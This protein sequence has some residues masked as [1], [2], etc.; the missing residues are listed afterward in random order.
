MDNFLIHDFLAHEMGLLYIGTVK[1]FRNNICKFHFTMPAYINDMW[2]LNKWLTVTIFFFL[3][4]STQP[5][6]K[7]LLG[8]GMYLLHLAILFNHIGAADICPSVSSCFLLLHLM[9]YKKISLQVSAEAA[10]TKVVTLFLSWVRNFSFHAWK[11][12]LLSQIQA[13][14]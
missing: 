5:W 12:M 13:R 10:S 1:K 8:A 3:R 4:L 9:Q 14:I 11:N 2:T 6:K 7:L